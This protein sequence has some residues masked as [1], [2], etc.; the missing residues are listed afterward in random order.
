MKE[1]PSPPKVWA[2]LGGKRGDNAQI[3]R[4]TELLGWPTK[5]FQLRYNAFAYSRNVF[6]GA[7]LASLRRA[8]PELGPP[9]PDIVVGIGQRSVPVAR[10]IQQQ[11]GGRSRLVH[12]GR[13]QAPLSWFD[14]VITTPQYRLPKRGNVTELPLPLSPVTRPR[15]AEAGKVWGSWL[16]ALPRPRL[17]VIVGGPSR[18]VKL[19]IKEAERVLRTAQEY[20]RAQGGSLLVATSPR[21]PREV[22]EILERGLPAASFIYRYDRPGIGG[23]PYLGLLAHSCAAMI[24]Q[25]SVSTLA[26][27]LNAGLATRVIELPERWTERWTAFWKLPLVRRMTA[28]IDGVGIIPVAPDL[29]A[30]RD[31]L[32]RRGMAHPARGGFEVQPG[33]QQETA[34]HQAAAAVRALAPQPAARESSAAGGAGSAS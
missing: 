3:E 27:T 13:P 24:T 8:K 16:E 12:M 19:G 34:I 26:D 29:R 15:L 25:D 28:S 21:T 6:L 33:E 1:E 18:T 31:D 23:N 32:F 7:S 14:H 5:Y 30:L 11:S 17:A 4:L 2:L 10:W 9:W 20:Q 22:A